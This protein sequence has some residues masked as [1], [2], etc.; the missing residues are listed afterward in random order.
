MEL[1]FLHAAIFVASLD[2]GSAASISTNATEIRSQNGWC[3]PICACVLL[4]RVDCM[5]VELNILSSS[6]FPINSSKIRDLWL[7]NTSLAILEHNVFDGMESL[8]RLSLAN[9]YLR[10]LDHRLFYDLLGLRYLD[11]RSNCLVSPLD[12]RLF[13]S[14]RQLH[15]LKLD[16]N[17]LTTLDAKILIPIAINITEITLSNN[18]FICDCDIRDAVEWFNKYRLKSKATCGYPSAG[19]SWDSL[20]FTGH[21]EIFRPLNID[22][23]CNVAS[24]PEE[25]DSKTSDSFNLIVVSVVALCGFVVLACGGLSLYCWRRA[26][27]NSTTNLDRKANEN[28]LYDDIRS[29][30][31]YYYELVRSE[32][33]RYMSPS[34]SCVPESAPELPKRPK[35]HDSCQ[36][37]QYDDVGDS[38][39]DSYIKPETP[40]SEE[41]TI[42]ADILPA[43]GRPLARN[44]VL[45]HS[46]NAREHADSTE[47]RKVSCLVAGALEERTDTEASLTPEEV[48][49]SPGL[50]DDTSQVIELPI[51]QTQGP[52]YF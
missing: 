50:R 51:V 37:E 9:N 7:D 4:Y 1:F 28:K 39:S 14:L 18:P 31:Y 35:P 34:S 20:S 8:Q 40:A 13:E 22:L 10:K 33:P 30:D 38:D 45:S 3:P 21:C 15:T 48:T 44:E 24:R 25:E 46:H 49:S 52:D 17:K 41:Q 42:T 36:S 19:E 23:T 26:V 2:C 47:L 32:V 27:R 5:N 43:S 11:L 6:M 16:Y 29:N 12:T